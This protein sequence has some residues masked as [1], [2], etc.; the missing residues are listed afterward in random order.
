MQKSKIICGK[1]TYDNKFNKVIRYAFRSQSNKLWW[2]LL[3]KSLTVFSQK[4]ASYFTSPYFTSTFVTL[5]MRDYSHY[6]MR[7]NKSH[8]SCGFPQAAHVIVKMPRS[9]CVENCQTMQNHNQTWIFIFFHLSE[10]LD[11]LSSDYE[12]IIFS[13]DFNVSDDEH[14]M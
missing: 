4:S 11:L 14:Q 2:S 10:S 13:G 5:Y 3:Q 7:E 1:T 6:E 12:K 8:L 9:C